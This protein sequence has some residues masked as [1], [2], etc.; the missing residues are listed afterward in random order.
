MN[1]LPDETAQPGEWPPPPPPP[2]PEPTVSGRRSG[3]ATG[4]TTEDFGIAVEG[5]ARV[6]ER[7]RDVLTRVRP[8]EVAVIDHEDLDRSTIEGFLRAKVIAVVNASACISGR[9]PNLAPLL[10]VAAGIAVVDRCGR[11]ALTSIEEGVDVRVA[12]GVVYVGD[13]AVVHGERQSLE[14]M[15]SRLSEAKLHMGAELERLAEGTI[16][17]LHEERDLLVEGVR[18]PEC[19]VDFE[20]RHCVVVVRH[21]DWRQDLESLMGYI[22][23]RRPVLVGVDAGADA[24][25]EVGLAPDLILGDPNAVGADTLTCGAEVVVMGNDGDRSAGLGRLQDLGIPHR[26]FDSHGDATDAALLV[27]YERGA[28]LVVVVG[29]QASPVEF[30]ERGRAD[31]ASSLLARMRVGH[32]LVD[33]K[34]VSRLFS[35]GIRPRHVLLLILAALAAMLV[36]AAVSP[37]FQLFFQGLADW[38]ADLWHSLFG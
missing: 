12:G 26:V 32:V 37:S 22:K 34:A 31:A 3:P 14:S 2:A 9:F 6:D 5:V 20:G 8:G 29:T 7:S 13:R 24:L 35:T 30:L 27:A 28:E 17:F 25:R 23:D 38:F 16:E 15:E 11:D 4:F 33:A 19:D 21:L 1:W 18:I 36:V 10:L